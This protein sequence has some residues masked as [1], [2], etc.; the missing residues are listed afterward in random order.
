MPEPSTSTQRRF[1]GLSRDKGPYAGFL[2]RSAAQ[3]HK[4]ALRSATALVTNAILAMRDRRIWGEAGSACASDSTKIGAWDQNLM[5]EWHVRYQ[6]RG[7]MI[8][9]HMERQATCIYSQLKRCSSS[10]V[11]AMIEGVLR[12]CTD[13]DIQRH[14]VDSHGQSEVAFAFCHLLGFELAPRL[15]AIARQKLYLP[16]AELRSL[17]DNLA[18]IL[19]RVIDWAQIERQYDEMIKYTAALRHRTADPEAILPASRAP[20]SSTRPIPRSA[21]SAR[22]SRRSSCATTS[23]RKTCAGRSMPGSTWSRIG[24][25]RTASSSSARVA[26]SPAT[27]RRTRNS[28]CWRSTCCKTA[29][30]T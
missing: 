9:W 22:S 15:K 3:A 1:T 23:A 5:T 29:W 27:A 30:S 28:P 18:P 20:R 19:S 14:Y 11:S 4:E 17:L 12:H 26:R 6:G 25:A 10:E 13:M 2:F 21:N 24:T 16:D 8:Y 7:V